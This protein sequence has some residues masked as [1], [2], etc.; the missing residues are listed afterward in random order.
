MGRVL[1][2]DAPNLRVQCITTGSNY[3]LGLNQHF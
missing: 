1:G 3:I 2:E